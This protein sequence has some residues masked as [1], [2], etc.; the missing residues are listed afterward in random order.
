MTEGADQSSPKDDVYR[1]YSTWC[2]RNGYQAMN[3]GSLAQRLK[4]RG[5]TATR[6]RINGG[7][8]HYY[9]GISV[10]ITADRA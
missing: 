8:V 6:P 5:V 4:Q 2:R 9:Q 7:R 10:M 3:S 1:V